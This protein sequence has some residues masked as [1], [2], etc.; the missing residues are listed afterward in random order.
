MD[1]PASLSIVL[2]LVPIVALLVLSGFFS[3]AETAVFTLT[4]VQVQRLREENTL[5]NRT[6]VEFVDNPNRLLITSLLG[7]IF[8]NTA[9]VTLMTSIALSVGETAEW[10][11]GATLVGSMVVTTV[12]LLIFGE[13]A[14]K[15]Y[16]IRNAERVARLIAVPLW[17]TAVALTPIRRVMRMVVDL[18]ARVLGSGAHDADAVTEED[19][20]EVVSTGEAAG[21]IEEG[22]RELIQRIFELREL[23][24]KDVMVPRTE[25][26]C[27]ETD[28]RV[29]DVL[30]VAETVGHSR[31]PVYED[32]MD[33]I[34]GIFHV[35]DYP[36]W[37]ASDI[38]DATLASL[39]SEGS[40]TAQ[41]TL[42]RPPLF[43]PE[44]KRLDALLLEFSNQGIQMA[45]LLDEYGGTAGVITL[46]DIVEEIVGEI[47]DEYDDQ[48]EPE[49]GSEL[50]LD[51]LRRDG[52]DFPAKT[53]LKTAGRLLRVTFDTESGD[54]LGGYVYTLFGKLPAVGEVMVDEHGFAFEVTAMT[55]TRIQH[56]VVRRDHEPDTS[57]DRRGDEL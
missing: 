51:T 29:R 9:F 56:V 3:S 24:A 11:P 35:K 14:P 38:A 15:T 10:N 19:I 47:L 8:I 12:V 6:I 46:E 30:T 48:A 45:V 28:Q 32:R 50:D 1:D 23:T 16:A 31:L 33:N 37:Y 55:G 39:I 21:S 40:T 13:I 42:I 52:V 20:R 43:L 18:V 54:T 49:L 7:N 36:Q 34:V 57:T 2:N 4:K 22:E 17:G 41:G 44:T 25:M 26:V 27:V 53:T 5:V